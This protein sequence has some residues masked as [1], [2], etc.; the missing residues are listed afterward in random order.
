MSDATAAGRSLT[1]RVVDGCC[2]A[3]AAWTLLCNAVVLAEGSLFDLL[4]IAALAL[5][6]FAVFLRLRRGK[7]RPAGREHREHREHSDVDPE[8]AAGAADS[9]GPGRGAALALAAV[10]VVA[11]YPLTGSFQLFSWL[12]VAYFA[13]A[14]ALTWRHPA[15]DAPPAPRR[16]Q[17]LALLGL[18]VLCAAITLLAHRPDNDEVFY[19]NL[20]LGAADHPEMPLLKYQNIHGI[21]GQRVNA[22]YRVTSVEVLAGAVSHLSAIPAAAVSH[23]LIATLAG[24]LVPL[25]YGRLLR[26]AGGRRWLWGVAGA[27][28]FLLLDGS[29]HANWGNLAFVRLYQGKCIFLS[30]AAPSIIAYALRF[31]ARPTGRDWLLLCASLIAGTGLTSSAVWAGPALAALALAA[32]WRPT[33]RA[34]AVMAVGAGAVFYPLA[35]GLVLKLGAGISAGEKFSSA[36]RVEPLGLA[37]QGFDKVIGGNL[38]PLLVAMLAWLL[39]RPGPASRFAV[40]FPLGLALCLLPTAAPWIALHLTGIWTF[41]RVFWLLPLPALVGLAVIGCRRL[42]DGGQRDRHLRLVGYVGALALAATLFPTR[43]TLSRPNGVEIRLPALKMPAAYDDARMVNRSVTPGAYVLAP[44]EIS[45][46]LTVENRHAYPLISIPKYLSPRL[47]PAEFE[48]RARLIAYV[49]GDPR[50]GIRPEDLRRALTHYNLSGV[51]LDVRAPW[52]D[53]MRRTLAAES[54]DKAATRGAYEM[55]TRAVAVPLESKR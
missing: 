43:Y 22:F 5:V 44:P 29:A 23:W 1:G 3:F 50:S 17:E 15:G 28:V 42:L 51:C 46:W 9:G 37:E 24:F 14:L 27:M 36:S 53:E 32:A 12:L 18:G 34:T 7:P 26:I 25:A 33:R 11:S 13:A 4:R 8:P 35:V 52:I 20:A 10:A 19:L 2:L 21:P 38:A 47:E 31:S 16:R 41:W 48:R 54:W 45:Q 30:I 49:S 39:V 55:W 6:A 40:V